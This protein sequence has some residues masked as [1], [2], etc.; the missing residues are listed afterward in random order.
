MKFK[1]KNKNINIYLPLGA[2]IL[3]VLLYNLI[4]YISKTNKTNN[5]IYIQNNPIQEKFGSTK[6][7]DCPNTYPTKCFDCI[8]NRSREFLLPSHGNPKVFST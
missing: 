8:E 2:L 3:S 5:T 7:F 4:S 6:C 1:T